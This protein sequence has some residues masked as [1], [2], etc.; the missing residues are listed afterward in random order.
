VKDM[1]A[2]FVEGEQLRFDMQRHRL[3]SPR[4]DA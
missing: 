1:R 3:P 4:R 2:L